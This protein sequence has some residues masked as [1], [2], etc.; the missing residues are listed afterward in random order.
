MIPTTTTIR[1]ELPI[2]SCTLAHFYCAFSATQKI[3]QCK[4]SIIWV[5]IVQDL[6]R[7]SCEMDTGPIRWKAMWEKLEQPRR[8]AVHRQVSLNTQLVRS[9]GRSI[10]KRSTLEILVKGEEWEKFKIPKK[11]E[12]S[13]NFLI[14]RKK[15]E[16]SRISKGIS[17]LKVKIPENLEL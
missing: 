15:V 2:T 12:L 4:R 6:E 14:W 10:H 16:I 5:F 8:E 17:N 3:C 11:I 7:L 9:H 1:T 13:F